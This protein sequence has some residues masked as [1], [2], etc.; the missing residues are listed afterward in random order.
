MSVG[1]APRCSITSSSSIGSTPAISIRRPKATSWC[2][3][4]SS[5]YRADQAA[6]MCRTLAP[7][8]LDSR[9]SL[10]SL[11]PSTASRMPAGWVVSS[12]REACQSAAL[13]PSAGRFSLRPSKR[14]S[15]PQRR[16]SW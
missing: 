7:S 16:C 4:S 9:I 6:A 12:A 5:Q 13:S 8:G 3:S 15:V 1:K 10:A 2:A 14:W 11:T